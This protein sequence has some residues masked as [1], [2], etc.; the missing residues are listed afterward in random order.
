MTDESDVFDSLFQEP[1][2]YRPSSP[3]PTQTL[4]RRTSP[5]ALDKP[6]LQL[7]LPP[8]HSLHGHWLWNA[9][10]SMTNYLD[11]HPDLVV[12]KRV[13]ELGAA[14]S[15]PSLVSCLIGAAYTLSTDY[16]DPSLLG[17]IRSNAAENLT[18]PLLARFEVKGYIWGT[19][20]EHLD[21]PLI[22]SP[23]DR[24]DVLLLSDLLALGNHSDLVKACVDLLAPDGVCLVTFTHH[25]TQW[26]DRDLRFF[27]LAQTAGLEANEL[28]QEGG[29]DPMFQDD[30]GCEEI[31]SAV[32]CWTLRWK[33]N[34]GIA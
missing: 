12:G 31:R 13:V 11:S 4:F 30:V 29:W 9:S 20:Q 21:D 7:V 34:V 22:R 18:P 19:K 32:H 1:A 16:P 6:V 5:H 26:V 23:A 28:Y 17:A 8:R 27:E 33:S 10:K 24:F 3:Q 25:N 15:L 14:S 2:D